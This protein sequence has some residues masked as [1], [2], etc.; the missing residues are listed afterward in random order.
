MGVDIVEL[1][2]IIGKRKISIVEDASQAHGL[3]YFSNKV[4]KGEMSIFSLYPGKNL[5]ANGDA[6]IIITNKSEYHK[7]LKMLRNWGGIKKYQHNILGYNMRMDTIQAAIL[8]EKLKKL[9][10]WTFER[11]KIARYYNKSLANISE[12]EISHNYKNDHVYHLYVILSNKRDKLQKY[13]KSKKI[14]TIIHYPKPIHR[15]LAFKEQNFYKN[16]FNFAEKVTKECLSIPIYPGMK[17][18]LQ[19][20]IIFEISNFFKR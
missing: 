11:R 14:D 3:N 16:K 10:E 5:G 7:K 13:L 6:G 1:R 20:K 18:N 8:N 17:K 4:F 15:H 2:K 12:L 19:K 9:N